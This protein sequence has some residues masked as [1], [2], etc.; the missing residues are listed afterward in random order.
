MRRKLGSMAST[1][2]LLL[3]AGGAA[4]VNVQ[5]LDA[6]RS[7]P[8]VLTAR[9]AAEVAGLDAASTTTTTQTTPTVDLPSTELVEP[10]ASGPAPAASSATPIPTP[11]NTRPKVIGSVAGGHDDDDDDHDDDDHDDEWR[12]PFGERPRLR[13]E[14]IPLSQDQLALLRVAALAQVS[15]S[16][17]RDA[18]NGIGEPGT[19]SRVK[20]AAAQIGAP[21]DRIGAVTDIPPERGRR[22]GGDDDDDH[23]DDDDD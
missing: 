5:I 18:A 6:N 13:G 10:V 1:L 16:Q 21:L 23:D 2:A 22:H 19:I 14:F 3:I 8:S 20:L 12:R 17:A 7:E 9:T 15:P 11:K 4:A